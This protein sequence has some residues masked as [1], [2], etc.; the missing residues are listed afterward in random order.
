MISHL[1]L[2]VCLCAACCCGEEIERTTAFRSGDGYHTYRIPAAIVTGNGTLLAFCEGRRSGG[3]DSG[4]INLLVK[5]STDNGQTFGKPQIVW[6]D[7]KNT[8]GNP[9][10]VVDQSTGTI[11]LLMTHN[12]G[13]DSER[14]IVHNNAKQRTVWITSSSDDGKT[15]AT[16]REITKDV[17]KPEWAWYA[18]GPG[19]GIQIQRGRRAG[20]LVIPCDYT[21]RGGGKNSGNSHIIY[22][23]DHG[24]T[25]NLGGEAPE[26]RFNECQIVELSDARLM[27][28][29]RNTRPPQVPQRG[30]CISDDGGETFKDLR[31]DPVLIEPVCQGSI[32]RFNDVILFSNPAS[33][34][35]RIN[36][37]VRMS[38]DDAATWPVAKL[39]HAGPSA[40][41]CL[42]VLPNGMLGLLYECGEK[43]PYERIEFARMKLP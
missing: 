31:H 36:M 42:V 4:E 30:V 6:A 12:L 16:P 19:V 15:W 10:P 25:W 35:K 9:C 20:R 14:D 28:N 23:D 5:R 17:S 2:I 11:W 22:S 40:Y 26:K 29:M 37:T 7:G 33:E 38:R 27:L 1:L 3:G 34:A 21:I 41:S 8:C 24:K 32:I 39:I 43:T 13:Q 18:T